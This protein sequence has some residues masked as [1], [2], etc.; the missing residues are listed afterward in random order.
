MFCV[1][2]CSVGILKDLF[3]FDNTLH[4]PVPHTPEVGLLGVLN[5][6]IHR[7]HARTLAR[8]MLFYARKLSLFQWKNASAPDIQTFY[9]MVM[10]VIPIFKLIYN[11][12]ACPKKF[13]QG[14]ATLA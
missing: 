11:S 14:L 9:R 6:F 10:K 13:F 3:F 7:T 8:L 4:L 5:Y 1:L 12:R 2:S